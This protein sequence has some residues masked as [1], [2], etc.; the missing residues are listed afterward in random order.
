M[1]NDKEKNEIQKK[2]QLSSVCILEAH[3]VHVADGTIFGKT[4][5]RRFDFNEKA[6]KDKKTRRGI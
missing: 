6:K 4:S 2:R 5:K 3:R 1:E